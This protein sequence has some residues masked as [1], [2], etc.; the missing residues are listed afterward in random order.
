MKRLVLLGVVALV[1]GLLRP[2]PAEALLIEFVRVS[3]TV[4]LGTAVAVD[5]VISGT[6]ADGPPSIGG[7]DLDV[8][9]DASILA[10]SD[11]IFDV[12]L[13]N[14]LSLVGV[15]ISIAGL[16]DFAEVSLLSALELDTL[17][18]DR[19]RLA[20]LLF[21]ATSKGTS[22]LVFSQSLVSDAFADP[23]AAELASG[24]VTVVSAPGTLLLALLALV[25]AAV[26]TAHRPA[27]LA[28][29][30]RLCSGIVELRDTAR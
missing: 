27:R 13:G 8:S 17:Q 10:I 15:D 14:P 21:D 7:Y 25:L 12:F 19:F 6:V 1:L 30:P 5:V 20:T 23:L 22:P 3:Q 24:S 26:A 16:I 29:A 28:S 2:L 4:P 9:F 11:V 18:P